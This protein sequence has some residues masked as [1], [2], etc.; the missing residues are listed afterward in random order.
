M[1]S[2]SKEIPP[3]HWVPNAQRRGAALLL[4]VICCGTSAQTVYRC[5]DLYKADASC[6]KAA[7][8]TRSD[9]RNVTEI[10]AQQTLTRQAQ[11]E[12]D[13]LE[14]NRLHSE[15]QTVPS[16]TQVPAFPQDDALAQSRSVSEPTDHVSSPGKRRAANPYFTAKDSR[17]SA[18]TK[19]KN[20]KSAGKTSSTTKP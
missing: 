4:S 1:P 9:R 17:G 16:I 13:A 20:K 8:Q 18:K 5:G 15:R 6:D 19:S 7:T 3:R 10:N 14:R 11:Q 12:A 2:P